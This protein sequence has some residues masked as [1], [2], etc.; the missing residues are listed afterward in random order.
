MAGEEDSQDIQQEQFYGKY[1]YDNIHQYKIEDEYPHIVKRIVTEERRGNYLIEDPELIGDITYFLTHMIEIA[2]K[3]DAVQEIVST[4]VNTQT[5]KPF[6]LESYAKY[7]DSHSVLSTIKTKRIISELGRRYAVIMAKKAAM[8]KGKADRLPFLLRVAQKLQFSKWSQEEQDYLEKIIHNPL[9]RSAFLINHYRVIEDGEV[10][11]LMSGDN[12]CLAENEWIYTPNGTIKAS[13][14]REDMP[15]LGGKAHNLHK[16]QD[17]IYELDMGGFKLK[18]NGEHPL[19]IHRNLRNQKAEWMTVKEIEAFYSSRKDQ[20]LRHG[21]KLY[22]EYLKPAAFSINEISIEKDLAKFLGYSLIDGSFS[23]RNPFKKR[24]RE[25]GVISRDT[26]GKLQCLKE[27]ELKEFVNGYFNGNES[28]NVSRHRHFRIG[29]S[30]RQAYEFQFILWRLGIGSIVTHNIR[31]DGIKGGCWVIHVHKGAIPSQE[32]PNRRIK[33]P[34]SIFKHIVSIK[35]I[36]IGT[37]I[38][39]AVD[40]SQEII[41]RQGLRSHNS[42][43][44]GTSTRFLIYSWKD[45]NG[46][47]RPY[48]EEQLDAGKY[49]KMDHTPYTK[50][51]DLVPQKFRL[52][53]RMIFMDRRG[54]LNLLATSPFPDLLY[55]EGN[56]TNLNLKSMD[57]ESID[58]TIVSFGARNK[59]PFVIYNYQNSNRPT[60][61]LREKFN[62]WFHKIHM[63]HGFLFIRQRL[64]VPS[65]DPWLV[66]KL[67]KILESGNDDA[68]YAFFKNHPYMMREFKNMRDMPQKTRN[69]YERLRQEAQIA[70]YKERNTETLLDEAREQLAIDL[71]KQ[72]NAGKLLAS[73]LDERLLEKG[74]RSQSEKVKIKGIING[75]L[76]HQAI[77]SLVDTK[78]KGI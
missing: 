45:L 6:D 8:R 58:E 3:Y 25:L 21:K 12:K 46:F 60:L 1:V 28:M 35:K 29:I 48:I 65:K 40:P 20:S 17:E 11:M 57:P 54:R 34:P 61:F 22:A 4:E 39:W 62:L 30:E 74:I 52:K 53:D 70:F 15:L 78:K 31:K 43:K 27:N 76:T 69:K 51:E 37:V 56:F 77:L 68:I 55:D 49:L 73:S 66:K 26:F 18:A 9:H 19:M 75:L 59:H 64:I 5:G 13:E 23:E 42:G 32:N 41:C 67:D 10:H 24:F 44:T 47:F 16:F 63:K 33:K 71:A 50:F 72:I 36:G 38:G 7:V 14:I 2:D